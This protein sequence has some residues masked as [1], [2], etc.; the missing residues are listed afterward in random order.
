MERYLPEVT[1]MFS[2]WE[3]ALGSKIET[4]FITRAYTDCPNIS[5]DYGVMEKTS[6]AWICPVSFGWTDFGTWESLYNYMPKDVNGNATNLERTHIENSKDVLIISPQ[7]KKLIAVKGLEDYIVVD[8][9][10]ALVICPK[11]DRKFKEF[12]IGLGMPDFEKYR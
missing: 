7:K 11:D 8:T 10:D 6:I 1:G 3:T 2:G 4:E 5:I 12:T 9:E